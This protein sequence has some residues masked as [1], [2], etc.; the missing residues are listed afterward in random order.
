MMFDR[1]ADQRGCQKCR[2][3]TTCVDVGHLSFCTQCL[4]GRQG[5]Q[6]RKLVAQDLAS[7]PLPLPL[8]RAVGRVAWQMSFVDLTVTKT[9]ATM[10]VFAHT[11]GSTLAAQGWK[12]GADLVATIPTQCVWTLSADDAEA[13][14]RS[15]EGAVAVGCE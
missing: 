11:D 13:M 6:P 7:V 1:K 3:M 10:V 4:G 8:Q 15:R 5:P 14:E 12:R 2:R 9:V